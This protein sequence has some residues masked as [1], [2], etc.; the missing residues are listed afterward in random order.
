MS[1][2]PRQARERAATTGAAS[3]VLPRPPGWVLFDGAPSTGAVRTL[4]DAIRSHDES[5]C[6]TVPAIL[7]S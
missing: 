5:N 4:E 3:A 2:E 6:I 7:R 1:T